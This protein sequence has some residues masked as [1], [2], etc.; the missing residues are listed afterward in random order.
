MT[1]VASSKWSVVNQPQN[2][3]IF[4]HGNHVNQTTAIS[5]NFS[6]SHQTSFGAHM[7]HHSMTHFLPPQAS[8]CSIDDPS[9][10]Q[11]R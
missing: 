1:H 5:G 11:S 4:G 7:N 2:A 9:H 6:M 8:R 10:I 3:D